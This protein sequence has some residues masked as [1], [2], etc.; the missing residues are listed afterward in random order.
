MRGWTLGTSFAIFWIGIGMRA[1]VRAWPPS[2]TL[3]PR[4][5]RARIPSATSLASTPML[6]GVQNELQ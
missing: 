2:E 6:R 5:S 1:G 4:M 3:R